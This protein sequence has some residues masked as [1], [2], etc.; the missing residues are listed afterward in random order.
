MMIHANRC[1]R[2]FL[3]IGVSTYTAHIYIDFTTP[4]VVVMGSSDTTNT[5]L[6][7]QA[8]T[9]TLKKNER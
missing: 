4:N 6:I 1:S 3:K 7:A 9:K 8:L 5:H 2:K